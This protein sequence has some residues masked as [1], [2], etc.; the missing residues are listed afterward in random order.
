MLHASSLLDVH[1]HWRNGDTG[2]RKRRLNRKYRNS[3]I[4]G[5]GSKE[6]NRTRHASVAYSQ[7]VKT[8]HQA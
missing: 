7:K 5:V 8:E 3:P 2:G 1:D 4:R 6:N